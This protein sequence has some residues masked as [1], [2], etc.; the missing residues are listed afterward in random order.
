MQQDG[1]W[2]N[3][4]NKKLTDAFKTHSDVNVRFLNF[5]GNGRPFGNSL[6]VLVL[7]DKENNPVYHLGVIKIVAPPVS[8][9]GP[10][11]TAPVSKKKKR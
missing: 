3:V 11:D 4:E 9:F 7:R 10:G 2:N 8:P 6:T 1:E 5:K